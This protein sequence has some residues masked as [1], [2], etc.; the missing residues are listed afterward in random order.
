MRFWRSTLRGDPP[1]GELTMRV[2]NL[3]LVAIGLV[4][5]HGVAWVLATLNGAEVFTQE[6]WQE[7]WQ[8][9]NNEVSLNFP[10]TLREG[11][12]VLLV[13]AADPEGYTV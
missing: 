1:R 4:L 6:G 13:T 7:E 10:I 8:S 2:S 3:F 9:A 12:N 11:K 5:L